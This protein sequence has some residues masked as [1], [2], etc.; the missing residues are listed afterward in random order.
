MAYL[1]GQFL[2]TNIQKVQDAINYISQ[3]PEEDLV[4]LFLDFHKAFDSVSHSFMIQLLKHLNISPM[5][6]SWVQLI[7][8]EA[9]AMAR[10]AGWFTQEFKISQGVRQGCLLSYHL[11]NFV[12]QVT[13]YHLQ[14]QG[15]FAWWIYEGDPSSIYTDD[16]ALIVRWNE[17]Q[18]VI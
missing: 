4:V 14:Q 5:I 10:H 17:L 8:H 6:L 11:F 9:L 18:K 15:L 1:K 2:G 16:V 13:V 3:H 7:Y 12:S